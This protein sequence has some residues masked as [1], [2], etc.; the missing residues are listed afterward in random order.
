[1]RTLGREDRNTLPCVG[2][3]NFFDRQRFQRLP[4]FFK[5]NAVPP[6]PLFELFAQFRCHADIIL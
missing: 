3:L 1:M 6:Y 4:G 5:P 2:R